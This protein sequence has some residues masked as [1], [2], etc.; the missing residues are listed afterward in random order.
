MSSDI[1]EV[2]IPGKMRFIRIG[3]IRE[4]GEH[5]VG[6]SIGQITDLEFVEFFLQLMCA[7]HENGNYDQRSEGIWDALLLK[8][9]AGKRTRGQCP[10]D[11]IVQNPHRFGK[12]TAAFGIADDPY[13][14]LPG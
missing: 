7:G 9:H 4:Q 5:E 13:R 3:E 12:P 11:H 8:T 6:F 1:D 10:G 2:I 14:G